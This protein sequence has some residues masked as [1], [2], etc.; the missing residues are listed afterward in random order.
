MAVNGNDRTFCSR[1]L[2]KYSSIEFLSLLVTFFI[3]RNENGSVVLF[4]ISDSFFKGP[5]CSM[6][7]LF[8]ISFTSL[9]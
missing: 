1:K 9:I 6:W 8:L 4:Q 5:A 3:F 7:F 2:P